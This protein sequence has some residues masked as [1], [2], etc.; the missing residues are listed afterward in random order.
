[1]K[2]MPTPKDVEP[3]LA[4]SAWTLRLDGAFLALAGFGGMVTDTI[5]HFFGAGPLASTLHSPYTIGGFEAHGLAVII[6]V[7]LLRGASLPDRRLWHILALS[8]HLLLGA[9][10][11][12]FWSSFEQL[13]VVMVGVVTTVLHIFFVLA[14]GVCLY[15]INPS[16]WQEYTR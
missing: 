9:A 5:G 14:Q 12:I 11:L 2:D 1:M 16:S 4:L 10:N 13:D 7:L 8:V 15:R 6:S 3:S